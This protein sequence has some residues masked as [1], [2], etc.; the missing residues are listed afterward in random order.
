MEIF[1]FL[2]RF[3]FAVKMSIIKRNSL[4]LPPENPSSN[5]KYQ[6]YKISKGSNPNQTVLLL[7]SRV[8]HGWMDL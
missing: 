4:L 8:V 3:D 2:F 7:L 5:E 1:W 6:K